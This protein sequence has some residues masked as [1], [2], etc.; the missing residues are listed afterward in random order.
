MC[1]TTR[2]RRWRTPYGLPRREAAAR[3][4]QGP[5]AFPR[6]ISLDPGAHPIRDGQLP[7]RH[8]EGPREAVGPAARRR[9]RTAPADGDS[10]DRAVPRRTR[11]QGGDARARRT[12]LRRRP[13]RDRDLTKPREG[14]QRDLRLLRRGPP[15]Y[16]RP[17][18]GPVRLA[19]CENDRPGENVRSIGRRG[20]GGP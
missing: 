4:D 3:P 1:G 7:V 13:D 14:L 11:V 5:R 8:G 12:L 10:G 20:R 18:S 2:S 19:E 9:L 17:V 6:T 15:G 16:R